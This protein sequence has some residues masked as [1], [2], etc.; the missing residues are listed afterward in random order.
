MPNSYFVTD[1]TGIRDSFMR[2]EVRPQPNL[3]EIPWFSNIVEAENFCMSPVGSED[4]LVDK[5]KK[6]FLKRRAIMRNIMF[7]KWAKEMQS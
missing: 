1:P 5:A 4:R 6:D 2:C 7:K 3:K